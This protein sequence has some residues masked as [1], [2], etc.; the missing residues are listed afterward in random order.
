MFQKIIAVSE[1]IGIKSFLWGQF[2]PERE[3]VVEKKS[4]V[5]TSIFRN[6][7][8]MFCALLM[9]SLILGKVRES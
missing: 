9:T 4:F 7:F 1:K 8:S 3:Q 5:M 2:P 6:N